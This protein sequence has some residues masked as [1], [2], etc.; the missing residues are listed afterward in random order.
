MTKND[1][2]VL[3][4]A[5][6][7]PQAAKWSRTFDYMIIVIA[8]FLVMS[9]TYLNFLLLAGDWDF[10]IDFKD[11]E[12]WVLIY[13]IVQIMM[14]AAFQA[15]FWNLFRLPI[16]ATAAALLFT[17][18]VWIERYQSWGGLSY[19]PITL[20]VP[21]T[22][23]AGALILDGMLCITRSFVVTGLFGGVLFGLTFYPSNWAF[24]A[25]YFQPVKLMD[26]VTSLASLMGYTFARTGTPEYVRLIERGT[27]RTF[28]S[29]VWVS[30]FF[31][32]F[33]CI[34]QYFFWWLVGTLA[35]KATF[36]PVG[37]R[38]KQLYGMKD[39]VQS[40]GAKPVGAEI[41]TT[42]VVA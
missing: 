4:A 42:G 39:K 28:G 31:S 26:S 27:L 21:G 40:G 5:E 14:A 3:T 9:V 25:P 18:G 41:K 34:F 16:G 36:I 11:R 17:L 8:A 20:V 13:P 37:Y 15:I 24:L 1:A 33:V 19:F 30:V 29:P 38:F 6:L 12:Y 10:F 35:T 23:F 2:A 22:F 32:A 7:S